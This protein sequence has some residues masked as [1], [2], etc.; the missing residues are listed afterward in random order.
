MELINDW[1]WIPDC[2]SYDDLH[3][4]DHELDMLKILF[5]VAAE[6][7]ILEAKLCIL[8]RVVHSPREQ[9]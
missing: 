1:I 7:E 9:L 4:E 5:D 8:H 2:D 3:P 6:T